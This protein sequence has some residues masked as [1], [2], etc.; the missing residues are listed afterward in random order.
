MNAVNRFVSRYARVIIIGYV[1]SLGLQTLLNTYVC[2][3]EILTIAIVYQ[4]V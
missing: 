2:P 4:N 1:I 3:Y